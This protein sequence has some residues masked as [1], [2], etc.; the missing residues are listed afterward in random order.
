MKQ[1]PNP[2]PKRYSPFRVLASRRRLILGIALVWMSM[3]VF[4][5]SR[6]FTEN[7]ASTDPE[8]DTPDLRP[9]RTPESVEKV[10]EKIEQ[11]VTEQPNWE[12]QSVD[13]TAAITKMHLTRRSRLFRFVDDVHV[14]IQRPND[15]ER[16]EVSAVSQSRV[17][18]GD[19][20]QNPRN[21]KKLLGDLRAQ[22][23]QDP[24]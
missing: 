23:T 11:W 13:A 7:R 15:R 21:L 8:S 5:W 22:R 16:T 1:I 17:G 24:Q 20:G 19:L 6:D 18:K 9:L 14:T 12:L 4:D 2:Q 3:W 10:A